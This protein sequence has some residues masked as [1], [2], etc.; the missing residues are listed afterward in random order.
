MT[1]RRSASNNS[2]TIHIV[3][4]NNIFQGPG[5]VLRTKLQCKFYKK[6]D[7]HATWGHKMNG[8]QWCCTID[9]AGNISLG[10]ENVK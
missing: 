6:E 10:E 3:T 9:G 7:S 4:I 5:G 1:K 2:C 8:L